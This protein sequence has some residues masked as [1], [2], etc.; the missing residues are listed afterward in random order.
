MGGALRTVHRQYRLT[1]SLVQTM[2]SACS[3]TGIASGRKDGLRALFQCTVPSRLRMAA[4]EGP[5]ARLRTSGK[6]RERGVVVKEALKVE[7]GGCSHRT[8]PHT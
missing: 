6:G 5:K 2:R 1:V 7:E 4:K 3:P 8:S